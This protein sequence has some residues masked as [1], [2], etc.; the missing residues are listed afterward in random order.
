MTHTA[1][2]EI[3]ALV[4]TYLDGLYH[5]DTQRLAAVFHPLALYA[6]AAGP[7]PLLLRLAEYLPVV[8]QRDPPARTRAPRLEQI[9]SIDIAGPTTAMVKLRCRFFGKD[10]VDFLTLIRADGRWQIVAKV[11]HYDEVG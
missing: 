11:F 6:T 2:E 5:C 4:R 10:Y 1:V 3:T 9:L 7:R 8:A